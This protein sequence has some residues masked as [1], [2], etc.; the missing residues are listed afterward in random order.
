MDEVV[1]GGGGAQGTQEVAEDA[2]EV[3]PSSCIDHGANCRDGCLR[4][5]LELSYDIETCYEREEDEGF[6]GTTSCLAPFEGFMVNKDA[7]EHADKEVKGQEIEHGEYVAADRLQ[8][9][10]YCTDD[11][12]DY[13]SELLHGRMAVVPGYEAMGLVDGMG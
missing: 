13:G 9:G 10:G 2:D 5:A 7:D 4:V 1:E 8:K 11:G 3:E 6:N 12:N